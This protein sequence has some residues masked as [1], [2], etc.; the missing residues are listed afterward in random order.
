MIQAMHGQNAGDG[1][2]HHGGQCAAQHGAQTQPGKVG[3]PVRGQAADTADL[4]GD[5]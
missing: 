4:D 3:A 2:G 1:G 5:G